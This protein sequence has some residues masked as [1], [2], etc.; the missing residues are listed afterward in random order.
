MDHHIERM[1]GSA[2]RLVE[3]LPT[4]NA[5]GALGPISAPLETVDGG[6]DIGGCLDE[7]VHVEHRFGSQAGHRGAANV[8]D[9]NRE[10][11]HRG[12]QLIL[13][14]CGSNWPRRIVFREIQIC[15]SLHGPSLPTNAR[16]V[17]WR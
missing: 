16:R 2:G 11:T 8:L 10:A 14:L 9:L 15:R 13:E 7:N 4:G 1:H 5:A 12:P 3:S 6:T 17:Q